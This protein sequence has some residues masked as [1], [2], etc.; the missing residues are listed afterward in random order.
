MK[1]QGDNRNTHDEN[2]SIHDENIYAERKNILITAV[3]TDDDHRL[4]RIHGDHSKRTIART[5]FVD[6]WANDSF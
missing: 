3:I 2:P 5:Y 6:S 4:F 1:G